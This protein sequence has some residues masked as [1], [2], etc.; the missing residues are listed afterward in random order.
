[1][2]APPSTDTAAVRQPAVAKWLLG[3]YVLLFIVCGIE[4]KARDVW[5]AE[6]APIVFMVGVL[7]WI[8]KRQVL[9]AT[10]WVLLGWL[11][12]LHT[13]G[14]H[15]TF[16]EVPF[17]WV[18]DTFGFE[19]NH[20]DRMAHFTVGFIAFALAELSWRRRWVTNAALGYLFPLFAIMALAAAYELFEWQYAV[21]GDP[22]AGASV[23]GSQGDVWDAQKDILADTLGA[24]VALVVF[25]IW[26]RR[27]GGRF[28][29]APEEGAA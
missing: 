16:A 26:L 18:T 8:A 22:D 24:V 19:R 12:M 6:N 15:Y 10:A 4:P 3:F 2:S 20:Y 1:M 11:P 25:A 5:V 14:G 13:I 27:R 23:L 9:S 29:A 28:G 7:I 21:L 17:G